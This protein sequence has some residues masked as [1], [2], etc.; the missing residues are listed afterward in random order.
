[1][2]AG[3]KHRGERETHELDGDWHRVKGKMDGRRKV[4]EAIQQREK[5]TVR[6]G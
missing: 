2:A 4:E 5:R 1:M 6:G 3:L